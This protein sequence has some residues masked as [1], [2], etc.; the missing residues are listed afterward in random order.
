MTKAL[1]HQVGEQ[2]LEQ[3]LDDAADAFA[4]AIQS[5]EGMEGGMAFVQKR[6]ASWV[7]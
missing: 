6:A 2:P 5:S 3:L 4:C 7:Q 1:L